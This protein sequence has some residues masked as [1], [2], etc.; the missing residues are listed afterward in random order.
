[1]CNPSWQHPQQT[2][3]AKHLQGKPMQRCPLSRTMENIGGCCLYKSRTA[4]ALSLPR[5]LFHMKK[6]WDMITEQY[7]TLVSKLTHLS[8]GSSRGKCHRRDD[9]T[10]KHLHLQG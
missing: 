9:S 8:S 2:K 1:M 4:I 3:V 7:L 6:M 5:N 10:Q